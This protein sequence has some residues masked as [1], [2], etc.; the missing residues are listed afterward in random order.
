MYSATLVKVIPGNSRIFD[1]LH[2]GGFARFL[3]VFDSVV[4]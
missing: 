2:L 1:C 3:V 4:C